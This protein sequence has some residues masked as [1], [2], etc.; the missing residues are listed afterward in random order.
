MTISLERVVSPGLLTI[1]A[2]RC[3]FLSNL[4]PVVVVPNLD[5]AEEL[6]SLEESVASGEQEWEAISALLVDIAF[7]LRH[8]AMLDRNRP[9]QSEQGMPCL[10][11]PQSHCSQPAANPDASA[12]GPAVHTARCLLPVC[13]REGWPALAAEVLLRCLSYFSLKRAS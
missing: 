13:C 2:E 11:H 10:S 12:I 9:M 8:C 5:I 6:C 4:V 3:G 7:V 1:E